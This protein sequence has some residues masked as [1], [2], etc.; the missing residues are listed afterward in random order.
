MRRC[1]R[2]DLLHE[3]IDELE[4]ADRRPFGVVAPPAGFGLHPHGKGFR[5]VFRR[6]ALGVP[7]PVPE[8]Q[9][10]AIAVG[11]GRI[12]LRVRRRAPAED[13][14]PVRAPSQSIGIDARRR[15]SRPSGNRADLFLFVRGEPSIGDGTIRAKSWLRE[16]QKEAGERKM[17]LPHKWLPWSNDSVTCRRAVAAIYEWEERP[18]DKGAL[19][20]IQRHADAYFDLLAELRELFSRAIDL[21]ELEAINNPYFLKTVDEPRSVL[22]AA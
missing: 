19:K 16:S 10:I 8:V 7:V 13:F 18:G 5:E 12:D 22:Y 1:P 17:P 20:P 15:R 9:D 11:S 14:A 4:L 21:V 6:V 2:R 3:P